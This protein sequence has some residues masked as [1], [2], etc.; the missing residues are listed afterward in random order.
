M[1][2]RI[3]IADDHPVV[4]V[5][6]RAVLELRGGYSIVGEARCPQEL[7]HLMGEGGVQ[8]VV[9]DF[10]MPGCRLPDGHTMLDTLQRRYPGVQVVLMTMF[11]NASSLH[12]ALRSGVRAIVDKGGDPRTLL[13]AIEKVRAGVVFIDGRLVERL[14]PSGHRDRLA[15]LS[16]KELEVLRLYAAGDSIT[17]IAT[18]LS[19]TVSTISRQRLSAMRR[20]GV[21]NEAELFACLLGEGL[22]N[23]SEC[24]LVHH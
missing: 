22:V 17:D 23:G 11:T 4:M 10:C 2:I 3:V 13:D 7:F 9:T 24:G 18:R 1:S 14:S 21:H 16:P 5:G 20:L 12:L 6:I 19:R 8:M 15:S